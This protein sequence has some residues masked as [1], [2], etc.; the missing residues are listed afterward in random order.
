MSG[1]TF[2]TE[3]TTKLTLNCGCAALIAAPGPAFV[4]NTKLD[5]EVWSFRWGISISCNLSIYPTETRGQ[6]DSQAERGNGREEK[7]STVR[8]VK[9]EGAHGIKAVALEPPGQSEP[10]GRPE[11]R[12]R[13]RLKFSTYP[14]V[15]M[16]SFQL[17]CACRQGVSPRWIYLAWGDRKTRWTGA[18][19]GCPELDSL[20]GTKQKGW[21]LSLDRKRHIFILIRSEFK[22]FQGWGLRIQESS[23]FAGSWTTCSNSRLPVPAH[24]PLN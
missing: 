14:R 20:R 7:V 11:E 1:A 10:R 8:V 19:E 4:C 5:S 6:T 13:G 17:Q 15:Y 16:R 22:S 2:D 3:R 23:S 24:Q 21:N 9:G 18:E 12:P